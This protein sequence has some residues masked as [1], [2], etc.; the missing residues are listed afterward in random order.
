MKSQN[1]TQSQ[2]KRNMVDPT[3]EA[4]EKYDEFDTIKMPTVRLLSKSPLSDEGIETDSERKRSM[5][6]RCW[7]LDSAVPSDEDISQ[8]VQQKMQNKLQVTRCCS[9]DSAVLSDD[10]QVKGRCRFFYFLLPYED[11]K[12]NL[13]SE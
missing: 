1:P 4:N 11:L 2:E 3:E 9:S 12:M 10:D 8:G 7:S 5:M 13:K 6:G